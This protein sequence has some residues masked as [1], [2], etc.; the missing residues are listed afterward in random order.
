MWWKFNWTI[1]L[2]SFFPLFMWV[3]GLQVCLSTT[4]PMETKRSCQLPC[5]WSYR[6]QWAAMWVLGIKPGSSGKAA[7]ALTISPAPQ[8]AFIGHHLHAGPLS[9]L[10]AQKYR[11]EANWL[12]KCSSGK[13]L[14]LNEAVEPCAWMKSGPQDSSTVLSEEWRS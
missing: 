14:F 11:S 10:Q 4:A 8:H 5:D 1:H 12:R 3:F 9:W 2:S 13:D 7:S 6:W